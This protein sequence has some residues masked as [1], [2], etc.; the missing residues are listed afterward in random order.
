M[1]QL[2]QNEPLEKLSYT[3]CA[4]GTM[5]YKDTG[6]MYG[7]NRGVVAFVWFVIIAAIVYF[8]LF[9]GKPNWVLKRDNHGNVTDEVDAGKVFIA[10]ILIAFGICIVLY[11]LY[12]A[13]RGGW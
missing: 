6:G 1:S 9:A 10:A 13:F 5:S 2:C 7:Y 12:Y 8:A 3:H 11:I 4:S